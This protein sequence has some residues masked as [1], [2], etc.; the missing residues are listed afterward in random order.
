MEERL[1]RFPLDKEKLIPLIVHS[2]D[3]QTHDSVIQFFASGFDAMLQLYSEAFKKDRINPHERQAQMSIAAARMSAFC[4]AASDF[5]ASAAVEHTGTDEHAK[6]AATAAV[7]GVTAMMNR[8][9]S[10]WAE[11]ANSKV[12]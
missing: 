3:Q 11:V 5:F 7:S 4:E 6:E 2:M 10:Q 8:K 12:N 1:N 9:V